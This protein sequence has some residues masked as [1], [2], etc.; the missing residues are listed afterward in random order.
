[1]INDFVRKLGDV[2]YDV[3][4]GLLKE[5]KRTTVDL[6]KIELATYYVKA[7]KLIRQE[8][9][10]STLILFGVIIFANVMG[11]VQMAILLYAP[12]SIAARILL[13]LSFTVVCSVVPLLIV[14][15]LFSERRWMAITKADEFI[16][17]AV[18]DTNG[19][20]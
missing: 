8:C 4:I 2:L 1:M 15:R 20:G 14:L 9:L 17:R 10:I 5:Y 16:A 18:N 13:A 11:I 6:A 7:V 19:I 12:W 3:T